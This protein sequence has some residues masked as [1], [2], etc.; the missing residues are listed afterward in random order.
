L[1]VNKKEDFL[2]KYLGLETQMRLE[3]LSSLWRLGAMVVVGV[4]V[5]VVV[6]TIFI[7]YVILAIRYPL[8]A[9]DTG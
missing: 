8:S 2:K 5:V 3:P 1:L 6:E 7:T 9:T 4:I